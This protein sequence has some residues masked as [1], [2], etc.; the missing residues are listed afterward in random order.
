MRYAVRCIAILL[1]LAAAVPAFSDDQKNAEKQIAKIKAMAWDQTAREAVNKSVADTYKL[2]RNQLIQA[3]RLLNLD[4][5]SMFLLENISATNGVSMD[6]LGAEIK[7]G[8]TAVQIANDR[9]VDWKKVQNDAKKM[10]SLIE[11]NLF[12]Q[13]SRPKFT[14]AADTAEHYDPATDGLAVDNNVP[15]DQ[16]SAAGDTFN[17]IKNMAGDARKTNRIDD[18][19]ELTAGRDQIREGSPGVANS[20]SNSSGLPK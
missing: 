5:G 4:Y 10:N 17:R 19:G 1:V 12:D 16:I 15:P 3:R 2:D 6:E 7:N 20:S 11:K 14:K 13:L 9:K 18:A 8:K